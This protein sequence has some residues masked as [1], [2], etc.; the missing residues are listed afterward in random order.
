MVI[1]PIHFVGHTLDVVVICW[2]VRKCAN[3]SLVMVGSG[4]NYSPRK[5]DGPIQRLMDAD[6]FLN[7]LRGFLVEKADFILLKPWSHYR[8]AR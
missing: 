3:H 2:V 7:C 1:S 5:V 4:S 6:V 8:V